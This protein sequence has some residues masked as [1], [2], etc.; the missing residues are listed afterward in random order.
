VIVSVGRT[1]N[2]KNLGIVKIGLS[3]NSAGWIK[4]DK[5]MRTNL[6]NIYACGDITG[7]K[8]LAYV[9]EAQAE[10]CVN[11]IL[12]KKMEED[13]CGIA[14]C[15]FSLPQIARVGISEEEAK[16]KNIKH[17][18]IRSNFL[19]FSS[20]YVYSDSGGFIQVIVNKRDRIIG[21]SVISNAASELISIFSLVIK[22][23]LKA[24]DLKK[25]FFIHPTLS[26]II[27]LFLREVEPFG[28][29]AEVIFPK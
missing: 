28:Q 4:T 25:S 27:P 14:D 11:N 24:K 7:K 5:Y 17:K 9:A 8:L 10:V 21:A 3:V 20:S 23:K 1:P 13:Y 19:K 26:E 2:T 12:K 29:K 18:V 22:N 15:V 6:K 16:N